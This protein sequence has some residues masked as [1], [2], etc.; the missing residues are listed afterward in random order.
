MSII[1]KSETPVALHSSAPFFG[2]WI[3]LSVFNI[4]ANKMYKKHG[5]RP[6]AVLLSTEQFHFER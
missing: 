6:V 4:F 3:L 5:R 1:D 2:P